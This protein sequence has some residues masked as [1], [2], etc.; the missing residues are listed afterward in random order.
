MPMTDERRGIEDARALVVVVVVDDKAAPRRQ[1]DAR[2]HERAPTH[3][4]AAYLALQLLVCC[5]HM[6]VSVANKM[7]VMSRNIFLIWNAKS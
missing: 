4:A 1:R 7:G 2:S 5:T 6:R 3:K